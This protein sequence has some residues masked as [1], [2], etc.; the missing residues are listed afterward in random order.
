VG[1]IQGGISL[2]LSKSHSLVINGN[3]Y[4]PLQKDALI[5]PPVQAMHA[6]IKLLKG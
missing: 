6:S 3:E 2:R 1:K 4:I 5:L